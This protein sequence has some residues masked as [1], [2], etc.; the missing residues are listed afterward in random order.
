MEPTV[1]IVATIVAVILYTVGGRLYRFRSFSKRVNKIPGPAYT[2]PY[3]G[4]MYE[5]MTKPKEG[6]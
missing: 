2:I 5:I 6:K 3:F 4:L 1:L